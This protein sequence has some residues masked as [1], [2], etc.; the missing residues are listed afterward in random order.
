MGISTRLL[1]NPDTKKC[2]RCKSDFW[3]AEFYNTQGNFKSYC[4]ECRKRPRG[5][6]PPKEAQA[7][8]MRDYGKRVREGGTPTRF[9]ERRRLLSDM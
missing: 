3:L 2:P 4:K 9:D 7:A 1:Q 5:K 6:K 8:Y